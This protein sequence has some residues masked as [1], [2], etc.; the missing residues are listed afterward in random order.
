MLDMGF[1]DD[2]MKIAAQLP[3]TCQTIMF[4]AT[5]PKDIEKL[6]Q[7]LLKDPVEVKLAVSKPAEKIQQSAYICYE[8]QKLKSLRTSSRP[9]TSSVS[10][11][12]RE[13]SKR[14]STST[15]HSPVCISTAVRCTL[16]LIRQS[17]TI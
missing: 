5:M 17:A 13:A 8:T 1:S 14:S 4:S 2:I 10:S 15:R 7:S 6:A 16:I 3:K 12:S 9:V 11:S